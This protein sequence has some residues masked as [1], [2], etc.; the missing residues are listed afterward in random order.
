MTWFYL[1]HAA[2]HTLGISVPT[3]VD[4]VLGKS[5]LQAQDE[6]LIAWS[7]RVLNFAGVGLDVTY[8]AELSPDEAFVVMSNHQSL[9]DIPV[10]YSAL[11]RRI[12]MVAKKELF[13]VPI[14]GRAMREAGMVELDRGNHRAALAS[15]DNARAA[16]ARGISIWIAPEGTRSPDGRLA[17][18]KRGGFRLAIA[19]GARILPVT[20]DGTR[21][22]LAAQSRIVHPNQ[23][24]RVVVHEP[25]A[26]QG[27]TDSE[28]SELVRL[29][30]DKIQGG[31][32]S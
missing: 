2:F 9:Y 1:A 18:F 26:T 12:R 32:R 21:N 31:F 16:V 23:S 14:W 30:Q 22:V 11:Q 15:L 6:R 10:I 19:T 7:R 24:V 13:S 28:L 17:N 3:L 5:S 20:I 25:V 8:E 27:R 29:V 4:A